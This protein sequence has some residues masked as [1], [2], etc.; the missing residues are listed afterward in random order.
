MNLPFFK[1]R[2][3]AWIGFIT[4]IDRSCI[5]HSPQNRSSLT[6]ILFLLVIC[7]MPYFCYFPQKNRFSVSFDLVGPAVNRHGPVNTS[8]KWTC[9]SSNLLTRKCIQIN[10]TQPKRWLKWPQEGAVICCNFRPVTDVH[11]LPYVS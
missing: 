4:Q 10:W 2:I 9:L 7:N 5:Y 11:S 3:C 1:S 8:L 6:S